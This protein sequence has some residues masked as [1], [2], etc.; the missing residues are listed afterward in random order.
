MVGEKKKKER[1]KKKMKNGE[2]YAFWAAIFS[3]NA[4]VS[5]VK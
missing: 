2:R 3:W 4:A 5:L 1:K